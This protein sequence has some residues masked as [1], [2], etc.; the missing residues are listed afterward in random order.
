[1]ALHG[2]QGKCCMAILCKR[3]DCSHLN[4]LRRW[5]VN[6]VLYIKK[7]KERDKVGGRKRDGEEGHVGKK[8]RVGEKKGN[9]SKG[10]GRGKGK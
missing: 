5:Y 2:G 4:S 3:K 9:G 7:K 6:T 1:M 10:G 8:K